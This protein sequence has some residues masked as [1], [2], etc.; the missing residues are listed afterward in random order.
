M[1][2][3]AAS[4]VMLPLLYN[5]NNMDGLASDVVRSSVQTQNRETVV[6]SALMLI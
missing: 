3:V 6:H 2:A 5:K 1:F 4:G